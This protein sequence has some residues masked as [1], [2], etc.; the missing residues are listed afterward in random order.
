MAGFLLAQFGGETD[1]LLLFTFY[2]FPLFQLEAIV[3]QVECRHLHQF[4]VASD[5]AI[6]PPVENLCGHIFCVALVVYLHDDVV[7]TLLQ[8]VGNIVVEGREA[9]YVMPHMLPVHI[10]MRIIIH[11]TK[12]EQNLI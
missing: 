11:S 1:S 6:V 7:L 9:A 12:V 4:H 10:H 8:Q 5:A 3:L 2:P